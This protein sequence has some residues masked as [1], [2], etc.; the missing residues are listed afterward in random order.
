MR[1]VFAKMVNPR[2]EG[3]S[4]AQYFN[5]QPWHL[6]ALR[7]DLDETDLD[8]ACDRV[9]IHINEAL[10]DVYCPPP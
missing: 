1:S 7:E 2:T 6:L 5:L 9:S 4:N 3:R 8:N 10:V